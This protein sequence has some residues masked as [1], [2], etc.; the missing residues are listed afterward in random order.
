MATRRRRGDDGISFE[1]RGPCRDPHRHRHCP[2][3]WRGELTL[4]YTGDGKRQRRKVSG[5]TKAAVVDKLRDLHTQLDKGITPQGRLRPLHRPAGRRGLA[6]ARAGRPL[7]ENGHQEPERPGA[8]PDGRRR[9]QTARADRGRRAAGAGPDGRR[10]LQ[11]G[12]EHGAPGAQARHPARRSQRPGQPQRR[13]PGRYPQR[14]GRPAIEV[15]DPRAGRGGHH[16]GPDPARARVAA[17]AEGRPPAR[18]THARLHRAEPAA[19]DPHRGGPGPA[20]GPR[21]PRRRLRRPPSR[22]A[23]RSHMAIGA[24]PRRDQD[25]AVTP[26]PRPARGGSRD[27]SCPAG[28]PGG[29][30][31][32]GRGRL[33]GHRAGVHQ[34]PRRRAG[35]RKRPED[36]QT[37]SAPR[38]GPGTAGR[39][40]SCGPPSSAS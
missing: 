25:R 17:R 37:G 6:R 2:G 34:P 4:G 32:G 23:A 7:T 8:D 3:L 26:H 11:R 28:Q 31:T 20:L 21:R 14:P 22:A 1:H 9:P 19:R 40:A 33:A 27:A 18:R 38:P 30:A 10:V 24:H 5:Q 29:G 16:R 39:R 15:A 13:R 12:G 36:V 35:R